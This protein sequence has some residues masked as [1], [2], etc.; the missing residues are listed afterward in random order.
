[1]GACERATSKDRDLPSSTE[2]A[3]NSGPPSSMAATT[4]MTRILGEGNRR[5]N[6]ESERN[7]S[8][9]LCMESEVTGSGV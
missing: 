8:F 1:L 5:S 6:R 3:K 2:M 9:L 4:E 7:V